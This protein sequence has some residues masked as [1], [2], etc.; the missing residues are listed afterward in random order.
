MT[1]ADALAVALCHA[2]KRSSPLS[3]NQLWQHAVD[4][5]TS[6]LRPPTSGPSQMSPIARIHGSV[7][8]RGPD[9]P[10]RRRQRRRLPR[11][12][13]D[14][15]HREAKDGAEITLHTHL[16]VREDSMTLYGF[17]DAQEQRLFQM[18]I[19]VNG[20]GP[21]VGL[22][23]MSISEPRRALVRHRLRQ[24]RRARP[25]RRRRPE[26]RPPHRPR[27]ARQ[28]HDGR[29]PIALPGVESEE[30]V[31]ALMGLGYS[32]AE[33]PTPSPA[34]TYPPTRH[35][36]ESAPRARLLRAGRAAIDCKRIFSAPLPSG[37]VNCNPRPLNLNAGI[38][39]RSI[40]GGGGT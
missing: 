30:V 38:Q 15:R 24:R 4:P 25:R 27:P 32:Q 1:P 14:R 36:G 13:P 39:T 29:L 10:H 8:G 33:A 26:A 2:L 12:R 23:L 19:G 37:V 3:S 35:R 9:S 34:A 40:Q 28:V 18:L 16:V 20:V 22:A 6:D 17:S 11:L 21:K 5:S 31:A 7:I